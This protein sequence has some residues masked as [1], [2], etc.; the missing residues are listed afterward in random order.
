M[1]SLSNKQDEAWAFLEDRIHTEVLY[2]GAAGGG[3]SW[4]GALW[5]LYG[6][7]QYPGSRWLMGR[8]VLKTLKETT[9]NSFF[10]VCAASG[11]RQG[12][13]YTYNGQTSQITVGT[14]TI[15]LKDL[16]AY[17]SDPNF[18]DLG[19]LEITGA[20]IDEANQVTEKAKGIVSTRIRY[21]LNEF[22]LM[23]KILMTCNPAKNWVRTQFYQPW[24][25][26]TLA[27]HRA[28]VPALIDDN[29]SIPAAYK[30]NL[31]RMADGDPM[32]ERLL[33]GNWDYDNDPAALMDTNAIADLWGNTAVPDGPPAVTADVARYGS[34]MTVIMAWRGLRVV[35][36]EAFQGKGVPEVAAAVD[37]MARTM[38]C[39]RH[40]VV[41]D[42]DGIG[43]GVVDLLP[44]C[45]GFKGG[46]KPRHE[47]NYAN[48][49]SQCSYVLAERVKARAIHVAVEDYAEQLRDELAWVKRHKMDMDG[50]LMVLP[51]D[52]V[53]EGLGRSPDFSDAMMMRMVLELQVSTSTF[54][55][56]IK[57]KAKDEYNR[58]FTAFKEAHF[59]VM[60]RN[61]EHDG[62]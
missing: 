12:E 45:V 62:Y 39:G 61:K 34:D 48:L 4:L 54:E 35:G 20:F 14:S 55:D 51:K 10:D 15:I 57:V 2:G 21:R 38:G 28:F 60:T 23:P 50:K 58:K 59:P 7:I 18:D 46:S 33:Y 13:H 25:N 1:L 44:G 11:L 22:G 36:I 49:K 53:K 43:G 24:K 40:R 41:V 16:F 6:C 8:A 27:D 3:K 42:D 52:K 26:G 37:A 19:S 17:P 31:E 29:P 9:L 56:A 32:K 5:L 47:E 30:E